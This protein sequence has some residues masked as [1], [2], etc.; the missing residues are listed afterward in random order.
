MKVNIKSTLRSNNVEMKKLADRLGIT[1]QM[2]YYLIKRGDK[3]SIELLMSI[4]EASGI[5]VRSFFKTSSS[6]HRLTCPRCGK[7]IIFT[8]K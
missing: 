5:D 1:R 8:V 7:D 3:N 6:E 2:L 4:S